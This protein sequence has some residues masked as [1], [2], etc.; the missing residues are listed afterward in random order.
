MYIKVYHW[1][2]NDSRNGDGFSNSMIDD[3]D[4]HIPRPLIMITCTALCHALLEWQKNKGVHSKACK[5]QHKADSPDRLNY[6]K[7]NNDGCK[8]SSSCSPTGWM[9]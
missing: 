1:G 9:L 3:M 2:N 4:G 8:S 6:F 7:Y 5:T